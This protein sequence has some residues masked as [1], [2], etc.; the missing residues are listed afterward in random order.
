MLYFGQG[1][2]KTA[3]R[4]RRSGNLAHA[5]GTA[6]L[7]GHGVSRQ[8]LGHQAHDQADGAV[9]H[10]SPSFDGRRRSYSSAIRTTSSTPA[11]RRFRLEAELIRD[12]ALA[13]SG[14]LSPK[15]G[16]PSIKPYQPA[17]YWS[18]LNFPDARLAEGQRR[19]PISPRAV[20]LLAA[21]LPAPEPAG[22][23]R[24]D[25]EECSVE[26]PRSNTPQQ[27]LV[28]LNDP[29]YVE[30][31]R[32][33]AQ[34]ILQKG[35]ATT[36]G[37]IEYAIREALQR[38]ARPEELKILANLVRQHL[39]QYQADPKAAQALLAIGDSPLQGTALAELA[40]WTSAARAIIN[41][42]ELITRY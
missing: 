32:V 30:A 27:A 5:S 18:F 40:A 39:Q 11:K 4:L 17:G 20:H 34:R 24:L 15:I 3:R 1:I 13:V 7:A 16:G 19:K 28:L 37:R 25:R 31:A 26:R 8:R 42:H 10:V 14:L 21:N 38:P 2:V 36:S 12:N 6:R 35:G 41:L 23:R 29:T 22:L 33:F 9:E